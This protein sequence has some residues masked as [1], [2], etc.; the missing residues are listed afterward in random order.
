[1]MIR[2]IA[3]IEATAIAA[4]LLPTNAFP[5]IFLE[6]MARDACEHIRLTPTFMVGWIL[7][8]TGALVRKACYREMGKHFTFEITI[9]KDHRLVTSGPYAIVRHPSYSALCMVAAGSILCFFG[10]GS[11]L[12][13][14]GAL[15]SVFGRAFALV[16]AVDILFVPLVMLF[17]RVKTEDGMLKSTFGKEWEEWAKRTPYAVI[18]GIY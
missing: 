17:S 4:A 3:L 18:P 11:W 1:M 13:E 14:C 9:Q 2:T 8:T 6:D 16:W 10:T 5:F 7:L 12:N 15:G